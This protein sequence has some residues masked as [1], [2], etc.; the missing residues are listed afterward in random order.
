MDKLEFI[1]KAEAL[2]YSTV[3]I[4]EIIEIYE[5]SLKDGVQLDYADFLIEKPISDP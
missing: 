5:E 4:L 3:E 1:E 2:G